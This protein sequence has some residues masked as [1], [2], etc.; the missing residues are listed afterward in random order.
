MSSPQTWT[1]STRMSV[2]Q[3]PSIQS[4]EFPSL[5]H[6]NKPAARCVWADASGDDSEGHLREGDVDEGA[7]PSATDPDEAMI[8]DDPQSDEEFTC[9]EGDTTQPDTD[10]DPYSDHRPRSPRNQGLG[11]RAKAK[12]KPNRVDTSTSQRMSALEASVAQ[13]STLLQTL[14]SKQTR[15]AQTVVDDDAPASFKKRTHEE[16]C[17]AKSTR[18]FMAIPAQLSE[19]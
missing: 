10:G 1:Q 14:V 8:Q 3:V 15:T 18:G 16:A 13:I 4:D 17:K 19:I 11:A 12:L 6:A 9:E 5:P 7:P 2:G